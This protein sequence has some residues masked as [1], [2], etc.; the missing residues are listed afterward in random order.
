MSDAERAR[1][2]ART[3]EGCPGVAG[4]TG[5]PFGAVATYLPGG[6]VEGVA[7]RDMEIEVHIVARAS[8]V[9][10]APLPVVAD[11]VHAALRPVAGGRRTVVVID[12]VT[13]AGGAS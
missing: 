5:G 9:L 2:I 11:G 12:D 4:L 13:Y 10:P 6:R 8:A 1:T 7:L 3:V